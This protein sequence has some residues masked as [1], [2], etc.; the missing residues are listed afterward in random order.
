MP[1]IDCEEYN[2]AKSWEE[3]TEEEREAEEAALDA[4]RREAE[5]VEALV[6]SEAMDEAARVEE[7][8]HYLEAARVRH[9]KPSKVIF[10]GFV[11]I[12]IDTDTPIY[13]ADKPAYLSAGL[14]MLQEGEAVSDACIYGLAFDIAEI[15]EKVESGEIEAEEAG[16]GVRA[17]TGEVPPLKGTIHRIE[18]EA[19][20]PLTYLEVLVF[21]AMKDAESEEQRRRIFSLGFVP[22]QAEAAEPLEEMAALVR[23]HTI[24]PRKHIDPNSKVAKKITEAAL[25]E[26]AGAE[27]N[28]KGK[29]EKGQARTAVSLNYEGEGVS[30]NKQLTQFDREVHNAITTLFVAGNTNITIAQIWE[31]LSGSNKSPNPKQAEEVRESVDKQRFTKIKIDFTEEARGRELT[32]M[33]GNPVTKFVYEGYFVNAD[34]ARIRTANGREIEGY[35]VNKAPALYVHGSALRQVITYDAKL[36]DTSEAGQNTRENIVIKNYLLRRIGEMKGKSKWER[37]IKYETVYKV[38]GYEGEGSPDKKQRKRI[39]DYV[40]EC[41]KIWQAHGHVS[42]FREYKEGRTRA[43]V[44]V[45]V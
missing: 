31:Q 38:A 34:K 33:D 27:L 37:R 1:Q 5:A 32:D 35:I 40:L 36:L 20:R 21:L 45:F 42:G 8:R 18:A 29:K 44:E 11:T 24:K 16:E 19:G 30:I 6:L 14:Y 26:E 17:I 2:K 25:Y 22:R 13:T 23:Q 10:P 12:S 41:M 39:N 4:I 9:I 28:V 43:G 7:L 15:V 3:M